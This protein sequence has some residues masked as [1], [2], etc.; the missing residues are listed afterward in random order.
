M[1]TWAPS[2]VALQPNTT[3]EDTSAL[4]VLLSSRPENELPPVNEKMSAAE[5]DTELRDLLLQNLE[6]S[7]IMNKL[8][9]SLGRC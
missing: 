5:D 9:V 6:K 3:E 4:D 2:A 8:K 7:G 1:A